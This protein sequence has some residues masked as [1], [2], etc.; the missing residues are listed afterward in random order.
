MR[1]NLRPLY[2]AVVLV[3]LVFAV[4]DGRTGS[5]INLILRLV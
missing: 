1:R 5:V 3:G 4:A 2:V